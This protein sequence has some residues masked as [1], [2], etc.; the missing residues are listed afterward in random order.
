M[1]CLICIAVV[2][3]VASICRSKDVLGGEHS[4][5]GTHRNNSEQ[6]EKIA[7]CAC[8]WYHPF[9]VVGHFE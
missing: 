3:R 1:Y 2:V 6:K 4:V 9:R 8:L 7:H 5:G